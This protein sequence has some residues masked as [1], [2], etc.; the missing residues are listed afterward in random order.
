MEDH[1]VFRS[2][3]DKKSPR[4]SFRLKPPFTRH[5]ISILICAAC[6][7]CA[8]LA[9]FL[10]QHIVP[11][12]HANV[13]LF[14]IL[15]LVIIAR[16]TVGYGYGIACTLF[17]VIA[18]NYLFTYPYYKLNFTLTGYPITLL[19]S[20][21]TL[22]LCTM[23][24]HMTIQSEM[25]AEREKRLAEA[26]MEKMR[27]NLLRAI[28]HDLRTPLTGII[29]NSSLF[30]ESQNDLSSTEQRTIMNNIYEDSNWLLNM[31]ENLLSVTRIQGDSLSINTTEEPV[32]EVVGEALEK[33]KKRY[34][35]AAIRVKIPEEF[36][37]I[38]MD[39]VLIEQVTINLLENAIVHSGS[40]L[41]IDFIVE[42][43][44]EHV[45][46]IV[47]DYGKGLSEEKLQNLFE[48]GT[49]NNSQSSDSRKG[50]GIGLSICQTIITAHHGTLS[51]RNH[52]DGA[53]FCF[54]LPKAG[55][56][57]TEK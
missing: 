11:D 23:T 36:L 34:P 6:M 44:P 16:W 27:A 18:I 8:T 22:I 4:K 28:S 14:Y 33:L 29:G 35:D 42:D 48:T 1:T 47:R 15:A 38:P 30:L 5:A 25:I 17:S 41:P 40:I 54:T 56:S 52:A 24:S 12:N 39:A 37:M 3:S 32:E 7:L 55:A 46:F 10:Y 2:F 20:G 9:S 51:G 21:I 53:E 49:Y 43:H 50:M 57:A 45:S 31:V 13:A 26:E 19:M